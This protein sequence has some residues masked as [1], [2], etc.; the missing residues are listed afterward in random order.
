MIILYGWISLW[1]PSM[2]LLEILHY[3]TVAAAKRRQLNK[4]VPIFCV[5]LCELTGLLVA[6]GHVLM[7]EIKHKSSRMLSENRVHVTA[8]NIIT[9]P[10]G[11][12]L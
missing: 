5:L 8:C 3:S 12:K 1:L 4:D 10:C 2:C 9:E 7:C 11:L 6:M